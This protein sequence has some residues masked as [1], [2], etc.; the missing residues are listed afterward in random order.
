MLLACVENFFDYQVCLLICDAKNCK[1]YKVNMQKKYT[2][3]S[4]IE[5]YT[6]GKEG[7]GT[8]YF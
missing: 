7:G 6:L 2:W 8:L 5:C 1:N 4:C 3:K